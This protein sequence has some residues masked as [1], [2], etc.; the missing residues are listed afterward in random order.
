MNPN[1]NDTQLQEI[2]RGRPLLEGYFDDTL[3][4]EERHELATW[5]RADRHNRDLLR[6]LKDGVGLKEY[7]M[8]RRQVDPA[9]EYKLMI[10]KLPHTGRYKR[11]IAIASSV[12]AA[13][14][15][16]AVAGIWMLNTGSHGVGDNEVSHI[17][18]A[19]SNPKATLYTTDGEKFDLGGSLPVQRNSKFVYADS[20]Q[21]L[22]YHEDPMV[23]SENVLAQLEVPQGGEFK[24]VLPDGTNVWL[25]SESSIRFPGTFTGD[26]RE[27]FVSGELYFEVVKDASR[28]FIV[29][30][31]E[32]RT[33][34]LGTCFGISAYDDDP[35]WSTVLAEGSVK[36]SYMDEDIVLTPY[37]KAVLENDSFT[38]APADLLR[39]L[40]WIRRDFAFE[41]DRLEDVVRRLER[42]YP[43]SFK[44]VDDSLRDN[45]FTGT[46]SRDM[47]IDEILGL[48]ERMNVVSFV[49]DGEYV[50]IVP[51]K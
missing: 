35:V 50:N 49:R 16:L 11:R 31:G 38:E 2:M 10:K 3:N 17:S 23:E 33:E 19:F 20:L 8:R 30:A 24:M 36:V 37:R 45:R 14:V 48:I 12:A 44:F 6:R 40:A 32:M 34:V 47:D 46:V 27:V 21:Q 29:H 1:H 13:V 4:A 28:P 18:S 26:R 7:D 25:N 22:V 5:L 39:E 43:V 41:S 42:W 15:L 9:A 51:K